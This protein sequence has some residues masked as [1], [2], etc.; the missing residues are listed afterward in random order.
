MILERSAFAALAVL[1][2]G[3]GQHAPPAN[4]GAAHDN[5]ALSRATANAQLLANVQRLQQ[6]LARARGA[7]GQLDA[8]QGLHI[9]GADDSEVPDFELVA[10]GGA[11]YNSR[12]LVG[13]KPFVTAFF[14]TWCDYC[15][16]E[17]KAM[18]QAMA[19]TGPLPIIPVSVDGPETW[20][21]V[22]GYLASLGI[23]D[24]AVRASDYPRFSAAYDPF[25]TVPL[26]VIVGR[27]G[28]LVDCLVGYDPA[29]AERLVSS[30]KLA[31][32]VAPLSKPQISAEL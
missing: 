17:L 5:Q 6:L 24:S 19:K 31:Q 4:A 23:H 2:A 32:S 16:V 7:S 27:N 29:H 26:L 30:L 8:L 21:K 14:A 12:S 11:Q 1:L 28:T 9:V 25:D 13:Q 3:C 20:S 22:P 18:Q 15:Q 10:P